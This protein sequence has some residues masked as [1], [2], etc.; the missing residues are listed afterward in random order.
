M[1]R[2]ALLV[3]NH[4]RTLFL[5]VAIIAF[6]VTETGRFILRP[7]FHASGFGDHG[8]ANSIGNLG[9]IVVQ[10]FF[11]FAIINPARRQSFKLATIFSAGY[12]VYE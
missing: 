10:I 4:R 2:N 9:G 11:A 7:Q 8:L 12:I 1:D 5:A 3:W 6:A